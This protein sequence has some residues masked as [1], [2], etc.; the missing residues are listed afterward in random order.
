MTD[1]IVEVS[2]LKLLEIPAMAVS[3]YKA[4]SS[5]FLVFPN[6]VAN[7]IVN[8]PTPSNAILTK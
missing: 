6:L 3:G 8:G 1:T 4:K 7:S 2:S 5:F